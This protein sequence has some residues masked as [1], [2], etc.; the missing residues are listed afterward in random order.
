M[1][2]NQLLNW[3]LSLCADDYESIESMGNTTEEYRFPGSNTELIE[4]LEELIKL[5]HVQVYHYSKI[6]S[7]FVPCELNKS[8]AHALW[9]YATKEGKAYLAHLGK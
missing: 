2:K 9:F 1:D 6:S 7:Q 4:A 8:E 3:A 5:G